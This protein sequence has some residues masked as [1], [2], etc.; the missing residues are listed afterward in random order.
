M[1]RDARVSVASR[2]KT[3]YKRSSCA[4]EKRVKIHT[5]GASGART[6][7]Q[8]LEVAAKHFCCALVCTVFYSD[9]EMGVCGTPSLRLF[10]YGQNVSALTVDHELVT[11]RNEVRVRPIRHLTVSGGGDL[12]RLAPISSSGGWHSITHGA[13]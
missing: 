10:A 11:R 4:S 5:R 13:V 12:M 9:D 8:P 7:G 6:F 3:T 1:G 2:T